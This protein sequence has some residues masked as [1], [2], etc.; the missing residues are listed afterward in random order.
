MSD[1]NTRK[2]IH[3]CTKCQKPI[4]CDGACRHPKGADYAC[5]VC[6]AKTP[7]TELKRD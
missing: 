2:R 1:P 6:A 5:A 3:N 7:G 4:Y